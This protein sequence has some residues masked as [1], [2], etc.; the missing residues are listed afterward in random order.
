M[1]HTQELDE[2]VLLLIDRD[3]VNP[4]FSTGQNHEKKSPLHL[5]SFL[6]LS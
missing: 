4:V 1:N 3:Y 2:F 5:Q 6:S